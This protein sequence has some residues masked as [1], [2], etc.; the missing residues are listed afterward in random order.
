MNAEDVQTHS[1]KT[2]GAGHRCTF[3]S[4][5]QKGAIAHVINWLL[6]TQTT[7]PVSKHEDGKIEV[8]KAKRRQ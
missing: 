8:D 7:I 1:R 3:N 2:R 6:C 4:R 5:E